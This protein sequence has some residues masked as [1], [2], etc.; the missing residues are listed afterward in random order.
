[1]ALVLKLKT[2]ADDLLAYEIYGKISAKD[3]KEITNELEQAIKNRKKIITLVQVDQGV[4]PGLRIF[5][6][7]LKFILGHLSDIIRF[8]AIGDKAWERWWIKIVGFMTPIRTKFFDISQKEDAWNWV[9]D[10]S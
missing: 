10:K 6:K 3:H 9:Q 7:D 5:W 2:D 1:M 4:F 8:V